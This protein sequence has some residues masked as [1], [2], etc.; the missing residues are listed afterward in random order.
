M[1]YSAL[2][3]RPMTFSGKQVKRMRAT[4]YGVPVSRMDEFNLGRTRMEAGG[5]TAN[6][7]AADIQQRGIKNPINVAFGHGGALLMEGH[8]RAFSGLR[9]GVDKFKANVPEDD[10]KDLTN[11][12]AK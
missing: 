1:Q 7:L 10:H 2:Y 12:K 9:A 3:T 5:M 6:E 8:H 4:D 11:W